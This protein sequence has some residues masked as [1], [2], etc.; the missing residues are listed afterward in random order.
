MKP[1]WNQ[2][3]LVAGASFWTLAAKAAHTTTCAIGE[4]LRS[5]LGRLPETRLS[6]W[7]LSADDRTRVAG[8]LGLAN[9]QVVPMLLGSELRDLDVR[10]HVSLQV[11]WCPKCAESWFHAPAFQDR[12]VLRCPWHHCVLQEGC[13]HCFRPLD[14]F[15]QPWVCGYCST[16]LAPRPK[17]WVPAFKIAPLHRGVWPQALP[18]SHLAY[19]EEGGCVR[20]IGG[21]A[22]LEGFTGKDWARTY[23]ASGQLFESACTLRD[24]VLHDHGPCIAAE[25]AGYLLEYHLREFRC[26][27]AAAAQSVF[28][29]LGDGADVTA[30]WPMAKLAR[31]AHDPLPLFEE[32]DHE[33]MRG[34]LQELPRF[35]LADALLLFGDLGNAG[36]KNGRWDPPSLQ[37]PIFS[38]RRQKGRLNLS[39]LQKTP[40]VALRAAKNYAAESCPAPVSKEPV[41]VEALLRLPPSRHQQ[42][43]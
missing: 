37:R 28:G 41:D 3:W 43:D 8:K 35:W 13:T 32:V 26:P 38:Q 33:A 16:R 4:V 23:W 29:V 17:D 34:L 1:L 15:G 11:R 40:F 22:G 39:R 10:Q 18:A 27:V 6:A 12:R 42:S 20:Y 31:A 5:W 14:P 30:G 21:D 9:E 25:S 24:T 36:R 7:A 19:V 2:N